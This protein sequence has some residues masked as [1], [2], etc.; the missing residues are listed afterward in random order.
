MESCNQSDRQELTRAFR[1]FNQLSDQLQGS[2]IALERQVASLTSELEEARRGHAREARNARRSEERLRS[3]LHTL[4]AGVVVVAADGRIQETNPAAD[5]ILSGQV[6]GE[7]WQLV[8]RR[9][10]RQQMTT[11]GDWVLH[12]GRYISMQI[13]RVGQENARVV[14]LTDVTETR[15]IESLV[16]RTKRLSAMGKM[17]A[18]LAHQI[19]TPLASALLNLSQ[20]RDLN[21]DPKQGGLLERGIERMRCLDQLV[22]DMLVFARGNGPGERVRVADLFRAVHDAV[23][24]IKPPEAHL[25]IQGTDALI[26]LD[27]NKTALTA[28]LINLVR[29]AFEST[30]DAVVT[31]KAEV[32]GSRVEF[33]VHDNGPGIAPQIRSRIFEAFFST[34]PAG[35]GLGLAVVKTVTEAHGGELDVESTPEHGTRIGLD[36]PRK[37]ASLNPL[38]K[39]VA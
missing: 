20:C 35:T 6:V 5:S 34:R 31:V 11:N 29:N 27:G 10:F 21:T 38:T 4:P 39:D 12:D 15:A 2:Y 18:T 30:A 13:S 33:T 8:A 1:A 7:A 22:Q 36:L 3:L 37:C 9:A 32:R 25:V 17:A 23:I 28:A 14:V 19:R 24:A 16:S 26:E